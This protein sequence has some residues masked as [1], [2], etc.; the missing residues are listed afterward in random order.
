[1]LNTMKYETLTP[2]EH[3]DYAKLVYF[4]GKELS[5]MDAMLRDNPNPPAQDVR[6]FRRMAQ[7]YNQL[8]DKIVRGTNRQ[9]E[10]FAKALE[11]KPFPLLSQRVSALNRALF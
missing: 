3:S 4:Q 11:G 1:T 8:A 7:Q 6:D 5:N 2:A 9:D 10:I